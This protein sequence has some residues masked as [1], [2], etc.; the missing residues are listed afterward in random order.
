M[1]ESLGTQSEAPDTKLVARVRAELE[2]LVQEPP[3]SSSERL[4]RFLNHIVE[5]TLSG[6]AERLSGYTIGLDVFDKGEDFDPALDSIVRVEASRLRARLIQHYAETVRD[7]S[8]RI[9]L[10]KG[11]YVPTFE[12]LTPKKTS[13]PLESSAARRQPSIAVLPFE[14]YSRDADNSFF[15]DGLTEETIANLCKFK[16]LFVFSRTTTSKL[17]RD[18]ADIRDYRET[19][20]ADFVLE[21]SVRQSSQVVRVTA[22]L[23]D[24]ETN[25]HIFAESFDRA[26]TPEGVFEIQDEIALLVAARIGDRHGPLGRYISKA[27]RQGTTTR[28]ETYDLINR[29]YAYY[30]TH[31]ADLHL[32]VRDGLH[33]ALVKDADSSD[34]WSALSITLL[35]EHRLHMN[36]RPGSSALTSALDYAL[37]AAQCDP[38]NAFAFHALAIIYFHLGEQADCRVS[39]KRCLELNPGRSDALAD[40]G[41]SY[42]LMGDW[43]EGLALLDR[44]LALSPVHPGWYHMPLA[45]R[46]ILDGEYENAVIEAR[47]VPMPGFPWFHAVSLCA[48]ALA[49][50]TDAAER[51][52]TALKEANPAFAANYLEELR[53][54]G[55][56]P[57]LAE[58]LQEGWRKAGLELG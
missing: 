32:Q 54:L 40:I 49:D 26:C 53:L 8:L 31:D 47:K 24:S 38:E 9:V 23:I 33:E 18:G 3:L 37:R 29:F 25:G 58:K 19:L 13:A 45:C 56:G 55:I 15:A 34:G 22:Q 17:A 2:L 30:A 41:V 35:D 57:E 7:P 27:R 48:T 20:G 44:A 12:Q 42:C 6:R 51:E 4:K 10:P 43:D 11:T 39:A 46:F 16:D 5:E 1:T 36:E 21:G 50:Q 14:S 28:W 52:L